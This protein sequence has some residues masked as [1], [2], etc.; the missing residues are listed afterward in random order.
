MNL[1]LCVGDKAVIDPEGRYKS[2]DKE[3]GKTVIVLEVFDHGYYTTSAFEDSR[4]L[5]YYGINELVPL[6]DVDEGE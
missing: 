5:S 2:L 1:K 6:E 4:W 3:S